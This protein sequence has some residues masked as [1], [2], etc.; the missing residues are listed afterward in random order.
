[1]KWKSGYKYQLVEDVQFKIPIQP[2]MPIQCGPFIHLRADG[3]LTVKAGYAWDGC[4]GPTWDDATNM[5]AG[6]IHDAL[7]QLMRNGMLPIDVFKPMADQLLYDIMVSE[8]ERLGKVMCI[9]KPRAW[10]YKL[11]VEKFGGLALKNPKQVFEV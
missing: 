4:S 11:A 7:Y 9:Y 6:L 2:G 8:A 1:M 5:L 10:M 3:L